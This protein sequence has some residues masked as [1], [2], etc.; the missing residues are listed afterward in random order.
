MASDAAATSA[1][2]VNTVQYTRKRLNLGREDATRQMRLKVVSTLFKVI[3]SETTRTITPTAVNCP[4]L[5][6]NWRR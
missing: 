3:S 5:S 4:A 1:P 2:R 6:E